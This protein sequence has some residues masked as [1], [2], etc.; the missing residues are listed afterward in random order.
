MWDFRRL[1]VNKIGITLSEEITFSTERININFSNYSSWQYRS[2]L[3]ILDHVEISD[4]LNLVQSA[5][6]TDPIDTSA[7]F[8][9]KWILSHENVTKKQR[10]ELL[11]ALE[12]LQELE[13]DCKCKLCNVWQIR[14]SFGVGYEKQVTL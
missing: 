6:F 11:E 12:Q 9:L 13:P 3:K 5:V 1:I 2:T 8:Y 10:E 14:F 4:E 7:W